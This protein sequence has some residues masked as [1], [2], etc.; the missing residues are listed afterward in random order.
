MQHIAGWF[1]YS[2]STGGGKLRGTRV[3]RRLRDGGPGR[4]GT[5]QAAEDSGRLPYKPETTLVLLPQPCVC[6]G[7]MAA[8][9]RSAARCPGALCPRRRRSPLGRE[10]E[11]EQPQPKCDASE[12]RSDANAEDF[13][14]VPSYLMG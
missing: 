3:P 5:M 12:C 13:H 6:L 9:C 4:H 11:D 8:V 14:T 2:G 1:L 10:T 7:A